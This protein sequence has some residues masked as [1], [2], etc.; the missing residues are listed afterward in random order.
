MSQARRFTEVGVTADAPLPEIEQVTQLVRTS[1]A[2]AV[3]ESPP[4]PERDAS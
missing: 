2:P 1:G 4:L 3:V